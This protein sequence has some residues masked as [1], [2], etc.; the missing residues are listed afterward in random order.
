MWDCWNDWKGWNKDRKGWGLFPSA[1][2]VWEFVCVWTCVWV[3]VCVFACMHVCVLLYRS[4]HKSAS[5][6]FKWC[7]G[8]KVGI[9][10]CA[11]TFGC[12]WPRGLPVQS[13]LWLLDSGGAVLDCD[14]VGEHW[15][16]LYQLCPCRLAA[17]NGPA[18]ARGGKATGG[19]GVPLRSWWKMG[20]GRSRGSG[21]RT[22][23]PSFAHTVAARYVSMPPSPPLHSSGEYS[24][25]PHMDWAERG[26][27][28][29]WSL[30]FNVWKHNTSG[31]CI[32]QE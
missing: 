15:S 4:M 23:R 24:P 27:L 2:S 13:P 22:E 1:Q 29:T 3:C 10:S 28:L 31:S 11:F 25:T 19:G 12:Q 5:V 17:S 9:I 30:W 26:R 6:V 14:C 18:P 21:C 8:S 16:L 7:K 32:W 20:Q